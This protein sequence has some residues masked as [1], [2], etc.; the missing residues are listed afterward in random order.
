MCRKNIKDIITKINKIILENN[1]EKIIEMT[2]SYKNIWKNYFYNITLFEEFSWIKY[3]EWEKIDFNNLKKT[4]SIKLNNNINKILELISKLKNIALDDKWK[5]LY[6]SLIYIKN[7]LNIV[8]IWFEFE[9]EKAG[10]KSKLILEEK[11]KK[12]LEIEK[13]EEFNFW[14]KVKNNLSEIKL[15]HD[16]LF[17]LFVDTKHKISSS[18]QLFFLHY[19][20]KINTLLD[21]KDLE[22]KVIKK[23]KNNYKFLDRSISRENYIKIFN[24]ILKNIYSLPQKAIITDAASIYDWE[25]FLEIPNKDTHKNLDTK[26]I[27]ELIVHEIESH[28]INSYNNKI[29]LW[30][31]RWARNLEKE[32]WLAK[33]MESFLNLDNKSNTIFVPTYMAKILYSEICNWEDFYKFI[34]IYNKMHSL[35]RKPIDEFFRQKRNYSLEIK[36][37]QHKDISYW[38]WMLKT[39]DYLK[40]WWDF[41]N[42]FL[43]KVW[44]EDLLKLENISKNYLDKIMFPIFI[45]DII[46]LFLES[47]EKWTNFDLNA[48]YLAWYL[49][50][51][52]SYKWIEK[53]NI[54]INIWSKIV[55][56]EKL[57]ILINNL[58]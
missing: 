50:K 56:I 28:Y 31:F 48:K 2:Y 21:E 41:A 7:I 39:L 55:E 13:I 53:F 34:E 42:L 30:E 17:S 58:K 57:I 24:Y 33:I 26:R 11:E 29:I 16:F 18:E 47:K 37:G 51:K 38:R 9:L 44:F 23:Q 27:L 6:K 25:K 8:I 22:I 15:I 5:I 52:Y 12:I 40:N 49:E 45:W 4:L 43:W 19:I 46:F 35:N 20:N 3:L 36:W 14:L 32:E 1:L 10:Y 54:E